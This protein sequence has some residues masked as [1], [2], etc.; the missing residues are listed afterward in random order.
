M[1]PSH[2]PY[3]SEVAEASVP[4]TIHYV[5]P[6][7]ILKGAATATLTAPYQLTITDTRPGTETESYSINWGDNTASTTPRRRERARGRFRRGRRTPT[8]PWGRTRSP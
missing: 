1:T 7:V 5:A 4:L 2:R 8:P 3:Q 6:S